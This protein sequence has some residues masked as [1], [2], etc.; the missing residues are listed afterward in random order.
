MGDLSDLTGSRFE[1]AD[2]SG[3]AFEVVDLSR[4]R[5]RGVDL[6]DVDMRGVDMVR[7]RIQGDVRDLVINGVDV[8]PLIEAE[9]DRR[10]PD[11][12]AMRPT[13]PDGFRTAWDVVER[14]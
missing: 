5:F 6:N 4:S 8:A 1:R 13:D 10:Y 3:S 7:T 2:M 12:P 9:L 14:L 11:R